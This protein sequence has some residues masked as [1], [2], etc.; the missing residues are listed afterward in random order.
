MA[1]TSRH[2]DMFIAVNKTE[3]HLFFQ[4]FVTESKIDYHLVLHK[5]RN[6]FLHLLAFNFGKNMHFK[7]KLSFLPQLT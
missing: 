2:G 7:W 1:I 4:V 3:F 5:K 6:P